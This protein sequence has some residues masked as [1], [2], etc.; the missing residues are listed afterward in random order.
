MFVGSR[1][2]ISPA[3]VA[4]VRIHHEE[5][6]VRRLIAVWIGAGTPFETNVPTVTAGCSASYH[7]DDLHGPGRRRRIQSR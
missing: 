2:V 7:F 5:K 4:S 1:A 3:V 6:D